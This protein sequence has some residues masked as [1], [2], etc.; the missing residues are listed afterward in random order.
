MPK[1]RDAVVPESIR[2]ACPGADEA[3]QNRR[4]YLEMSTKRLRAWLAD[5]DA[6][7]V[8]WLFL[9]GFLCGLVLGLMLVWR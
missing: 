6:T 2:S 5:L 7:G 3:E 9:C 8:F 4:T 1:L